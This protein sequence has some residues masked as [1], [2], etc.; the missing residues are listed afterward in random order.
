M[1]LGQNGRS[2]G[3]KIKAPKG[4]NVNVHAEN[5]TLKKLEV[6]GLQDGRNLDGS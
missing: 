6:D 3:L 2:I 4:L 5:W 1:A